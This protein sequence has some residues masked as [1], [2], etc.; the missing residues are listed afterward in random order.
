MNTTQPVAIVTAAST[1]TGIGAGIARELA[2]RGYRL[3]LFARSDAVNALAKEV[4][5]IAVQGSV[6]EPN[7][8]AH[9]VD[10]T[11]KKF[12]RIDGLVNHTGSP[13]KGELLGMPDEDWY[14]GVDMLLLNVVRMT[15]LVT[16]VMEK[17]KRGAILNI[18]AFT[19]KQPELTYPVGSVLR[20]GLDA[21][22]KL[23]AN[24]YGPSGLRMNN[25]LPGFLDN[26]PP[27]PA[28]LEQ[29]PLRRNGTMTELG[30]TAAFLIS[31]DAGYITG[32]SILLDGGLVR[33][34]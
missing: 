24:R 1:S 29:T 14:S 5:G 33:G 17:Q 26:Y 4:D 20:A 30:K 12:G 15:R 18:T 28:I 10:V 23:F 2:K 13:P 19:A 9:L 7:D 11:L 34:V 32:Q 27:N 21:F 25:L 6:T 3:V 22:T 8:L 31:D 16:P